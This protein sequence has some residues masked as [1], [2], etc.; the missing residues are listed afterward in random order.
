MLKIVK[1]FNTLQVLIGILF[2][3]A[4][5]LGKVQYMFFT[6]EQQKIKID[7]F[8]HNLHR[9]YTLLYM[10]TFIHVYIY[11]SYFINLLQL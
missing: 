2:L 6:N 10:Y 8:N 9:N 1:I 3:L 5:I 11:I 4:C 7:T